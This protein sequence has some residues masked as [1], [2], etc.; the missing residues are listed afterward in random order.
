MVTSLPV[1]T[2]MCESI[3][4]VLELDEETYKVNTQPTLSH[5][6][7]GTGKDVTIREMAEAM[8]QVVS[9]TGKLSFDTTKPDGSPRKLIDVTRLTKMGWGYSVELKDGL[10]K[11]YDWYLGSVK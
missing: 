2:L 1:P 8:K 9:Y 4:F 5:I 6:N 3:V 10:S 11:T 7:V